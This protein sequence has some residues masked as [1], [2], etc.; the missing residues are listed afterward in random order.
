MISALEFLALV[1]LGSFLGIRAFDLFLRLR[2]SWRVTGRLLFNV[3]TRRIGTGEKPEILGPPEEWRPLHLNLWQRLLF[4]IRLRR[5]PANAN[6]GSH[7]ASP[8]AKK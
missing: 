5:V 4:C 3:H 8:E 6:D 1:S 2:T 7:A